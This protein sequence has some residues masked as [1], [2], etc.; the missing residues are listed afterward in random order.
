MVRTS[1]NSAVHCV[2]RDVSA[3]LG[4]DIRLEV[5]GGVK[6]DNI[7]RVAAAGADTYVAGSAIFGKPDYKAVI[8]AMRQQ[9]AVTGRP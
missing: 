4:K 7:A 5:D 2:V 1:T 6:T 9:L 8:D 3:D